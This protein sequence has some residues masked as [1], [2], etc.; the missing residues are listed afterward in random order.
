MFNLQEPGEH[1]YCGDGIDLKH[2]FSYTPENLMNNGI[3]FFN[4]YWQDLTNPTFEKILSAAQ[5]VD[6]IIKHNH[7]KVLIHC[8]A[9]M[10]RTALLVG[11]YLLYSGHASDD[12]EAIKITKVSRPKC[13]EKGYNVKFM[14]LFHEFLVK[15]RFIFP[16]PSNQFDSPPPKHL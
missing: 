8:H 14:K 5:V 15:L 6:F 13:F 3:S 16:L 7:G 2:G 9:G 1:P 11:A 10:G 4:F 12:K